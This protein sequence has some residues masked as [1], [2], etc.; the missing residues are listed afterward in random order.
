MYQP[1]DAQGVDAEPAV[2]YTAVP[3]ASTTSTDAVPSTT[4]DEDLAGH[5]GA[6]AHPRGAE[7][8]GDAELSAGRD[9]DGERDQAEGADDHADVAGEVVVVRSHAAELGIGHLAEHAGEHEDGDQREAEQADHHHRL[10][11]HAAAAP[12]RRAGWRW[13]RPVTARPGG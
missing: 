6:G 10:A 11:E 2:P 4:P 9:V 1:S 3:A 8:A 7:A 12:W 5:H 13:S